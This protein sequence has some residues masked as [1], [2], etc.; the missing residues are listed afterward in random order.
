MWVALLIVHGLLAFFLL[1]A[2]THQAVAVLKKSKQT[3]TFV[4][5]F[6]SVNPAG[7]A[8]AIIWLYI[9]TFIMGAWIYTQYRVDVRPIFEDTGRLNMFA[10]F[11]LKEHYAA[12]GLAFLPLYGHLWQVKSGV[13]GSDV[14]TGRRWITV[15]LA[16]FVWFIFLAGHIVNNAR[17]L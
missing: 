3:G 5:R 17:G 7:Y 12:F 2:L 8:K 15:A 1:G 16:C 4:Q 6:T 14:S 13:D 11:E 10:L 9:V